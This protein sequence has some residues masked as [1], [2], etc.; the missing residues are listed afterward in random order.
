MVYTI[1]ERS[2]KELC[3]L[4]PVDAEEYDSYKEERINRLLRDKMVGKSKLPKEIS[5]K[6]LTEKQHIENYL[7]SLNFFWFEEAARIFLYGMSL[8]EN[9][10]KL[11]TLTQPLGLVFL[12]EI[13]PS[14]NLKA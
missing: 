12:I 7:K 1:K 9:N 8:D 3:E 5:R 11:E 14:V 4:A 2:V 6:D 10:F 13:F